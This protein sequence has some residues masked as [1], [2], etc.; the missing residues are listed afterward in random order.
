MYSEPCVCVS[1][2]TIDKYTHVV[3]VVMRTMYFFKGIIFS[4]EAFSFNQKNSSCEEQMSPPAKPARH[5]A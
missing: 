1:P 4:K 5:G 2:I 3:M